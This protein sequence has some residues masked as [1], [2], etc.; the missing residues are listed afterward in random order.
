MSEFMKWHPGETILE[1]MIERKQTAGKLAK[2]A[3]V[4]RAYL[5]RVI[6]GKDSI[7]EKLADGLCEAW[8][9]SAYSWLALQNIYD[10]EKATP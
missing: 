10:K 8:G 6:S 7:N 3:G 2:A 9:V 5:M 4:D 1:E